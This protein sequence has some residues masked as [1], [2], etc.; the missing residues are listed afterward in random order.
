[1]GELTQPYELTVSHTPQK[2]RFYLARER[3]LEGVF[4][5]QHGL[6]AGIRF[7]H[8]GVEAQDVRDELFV[9]GFEQAED[10]QQA[11]DGA[12]RVGPAA[13]AKQEDV[14]AILVVVHQI[15]I[16]IAD[17]IHQSRAEGHALKL[18]PPLRD[19]VVGVGRPQGADAR[20]VVGNLL[21]PDVQRVVELHNVRIRLRMIEIISCAITAD[22]NILGHR[23][24]RL[25]GELAK[26]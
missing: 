11:A 8:F 18:R 2:K 21:R 4:G 5:G 7:G 25:W 16:G 15:A 23:A 12:R 10:V 20:V 14:V 26:S 24:I 3:V 22:D 19:A 1:M 9:A 17:V 13:E 6:Q